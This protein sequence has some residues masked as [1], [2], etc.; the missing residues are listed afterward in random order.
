MSLKR[1]EIVKKIRNGSTN[2][3]GKFTQSVRRIVQDVKDEGSASGQTK[4][5]VIETNER[6]RAVRLR[7]DES[8]DTAKKALVSLMSKY[9]NSKSVH[10]VFQRYN[11]L[12]TM[13]KV[14]TE[15]GAEGDVF[16]TFACPPILRLPPAVVRRYPSATFSSSQ[17]LYRC[18]SFIFISL[19]FFQFAAA[20][21]MF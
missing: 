5:E 12:K 13:I 17:L 11:L 8:Y 2:L 10:N 14:I 20:L 9:N 15:L 21:P 19:T 6:L 3:V 4:E 1:S 7:L 18:F 16:A